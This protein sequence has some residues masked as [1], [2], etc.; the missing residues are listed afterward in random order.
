[1]SQLVSMETGERGGYGTGV[2]GRAGGEESR[3]ISKEEV[4]EYLKDMDFPAARDVLVRDAERRCAPQKVVD[5]LERLPDREFRGVSDV[6][7]A[8]RRLS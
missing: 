6:D 1:M 3:F 8:V 4:A 7:D 2:A 5:V